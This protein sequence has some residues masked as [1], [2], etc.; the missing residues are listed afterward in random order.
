MI[1]LFFFLVGQKV[2]KLKSNCTKYNHRGYKIEI[3]VQSQIVPPLDVWIKFLETKYWH[4][5]QLK[6]WMMTKKA[7]IF[8]SCFGSNKI[9]T[10]KEIKNKN[11]LLFAQTLYLKNVNV[12]LNFFMKNSQFFPTVSTTYIHKKR[13]NN[14]Y[15]ALIQHP[16]KKLQTYRILTDFES[17]SFLDCLIR[18]F[19]PPYV[20]T[21]SV[22]FFFSWKTFIF[23][24][25]Y[26]KCEEVNKT[27]SEMDKKKYIV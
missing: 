15:K 21:F 9:W 23:W 22:Q 14:L 8:E 2:R 3:K 5:L 7:R 12:S 25:T 27:K 10:F 24:Q 26:M 17:W 13:T 6:L 4:V 20:K 16:S 18:L 11:G 1:R 19:R